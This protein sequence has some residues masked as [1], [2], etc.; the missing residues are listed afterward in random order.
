MKENMHNS[1]E[2]Q[3]LDG[4]ISLTSKSK[5]LGKLDNFWFYY[6]WHVIIGAF[7]LIVLTIGLVQLF[8]RTQH[9]VAVSFAG[10]VHITPIQSADIETELSK[11]LTDD[12]TG[13]GN[14]KVKFTAYSVFSEDDIKQSGG[15]VDT[16]QNTTNISNFGDYVSSGECSIYFVSSYRYENLKTYERLRPLNEI[17]D[18]QLPSGITEDGYGIRLGDLPIYELDAFK[19]L[20][21]DTYLCMTKPYI[22]GDSSKADKYEDMTKCFKAIVNFGG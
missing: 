1:V 16:S 17:F 20:P 19:V 12:L 22:Y 3:K 7:F 15:N 6:K 11:I 8:G 18:G 21:E 4:D 10:P 5:L 13:N 14:K 9:D 2:E